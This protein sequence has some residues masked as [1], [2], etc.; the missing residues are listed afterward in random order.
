M[1]K[2]LQAS[3]QK[4]W[5]HHQEQQLALLPFQAKMHRALVASGDEY[6]L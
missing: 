3:A 5:R 4:V 6:I 2:E 1:G